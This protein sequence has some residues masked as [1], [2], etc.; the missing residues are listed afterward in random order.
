[1]FQRV[2]IAN[3]GE[4]AVRIIRACQELGI[5]TVAVYSDVDAEALHVRLAD[6][7]CHIGPAEAQESYLNGPAIIAAALAADVDAIHPGYGFLSENA[8]FAEAVAAAG[9]TY[10]GPLPE[11][12]R[13][14]G[15]KDAAREAMQRAGL[16]LITG[17]D[18]IMD[19][20]DV[21]KIAAAVGYPL[22]A[23][24][25]SG[26]G[27]NGMFT[28]HDEEE[29][30]RKLEM[31]AFVPGSLYFERYVCD[32]RHIEIQIMADNYGH[33]IHL[34]ERECSLQRRNQKILEEAPS[35][36]LTSEMRQKVGALA[37]LAAK[38]VNYTNIGTV[39]FLMDKQNRQFYFM[40]INPRIQVEHGITETITRMD[41]VRKQIRIAA[42]E[43]LNVKQDNIR[44]N[45]HAIE[46]RINAEDPE[47]NFMPWPGTIDYYHQPGGP[48][49]R[50]DSGVCCG[51]VVQ[52]YYD[53]LIAKIIVHGR[54]RGD[55]IRIMKRAL[56]EFHI[57]GIKTT[58]DLHCRVLSDPQ[59]CSGNI[60]TQFVQKFLKP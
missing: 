30:L 3:R 28:A 42:G 33:I 55:A 54:T 36:A 26:G 32:A 11:T 35:S 7:A 50:V 15:N 52:P 45:G 37:I 14:V 21:P 51:S 34:G 10:I 49:V 38:S 40:E 13:M 44:F 12:I 39:E 22:I 1:M 4:I 17:S 31:T 53:S 57:Q 59:F 19:I 16:P 47:L 8:D 9:I 58:I 23:K 18:P 60:S 27:G 5:E 41:I 48:N 46:C 6:Y 29:L 20:T 2:L 25:I 43:P 56:A 24:P